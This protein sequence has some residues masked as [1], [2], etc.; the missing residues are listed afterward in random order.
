[1]VI[2]SYKVVVSLYFFSWCYF[3]FTI[4]ITIGSNISLTMFAVF[5][6]I[7]YSHPFRYFVFSVAIPPFFR[8]E[9]GGIFFD[10]AAV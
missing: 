7:S 5:D 6:V 3:Y 2:V 4:T 8:R 1:M 10:C 9:C